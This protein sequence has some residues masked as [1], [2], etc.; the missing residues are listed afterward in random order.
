MTSRHSIGV[1]LGPRSYAVEVG[2]GLLDAAG[3]LVAPLLKRGRVGLVS[4]P[5]VWAAHGPRLIASLREAGIETTVHIA[6]AG[7]GAKS[8][9]ELERVCEAFVEAELERGDALIAF[10]GGVVGD[11]AGLAAGLIKRG[12]DVVQVPTTLLSQVDSSVGG[13]TAINLR[14]GKNLVGLFH[15]PR[16]VIADLDTLKTLPKRELRAGYA[17]VVKYALIDDPDLFVWLEDNGHAALAGV[18]NALAHAV[19]TSIHSKARIVAADERETGVRALLNL[20]HTFGH[21]FE[22]CAGYDGRLLHGEAVAC[23]LAMA[24]RLSV[25]LGLCPGEDAAR[26]E[27]HLALAGLHPDPQRLPGGP[28]E[29]GS[30]LA[31]MAHDKKNEGGSLT[32]ILLR[33]IGQAFVQKRAD[34]GAVLSLLDDSL[35]RRP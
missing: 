6:P 1:D 16:L 15:Q 13:K 9:A 29:A 32:L 22:A 4:D 8:F 10:G 23:G 30:L 17:E 24:A 26:L 20:G 5:N 25:R 18:E 11:L 12:L 21:A 3:G 34:T 19:A 31:A 7:E 28:Y 33:G 35:G 14:S 2:P 27:T